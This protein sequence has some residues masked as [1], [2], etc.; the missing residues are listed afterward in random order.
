M[1]S[2][3]R[4]DDPDDETTNSTALATMPDDDGY[5]AAAVE[6]DRHL[7][8]GEIVKFVDGTWSINKV[9]VAKDARFIPIKLAMA[10]VKW[11]NQRPV[12]YVWPKPNGFLPARESLGDTDESKWPAGLD[13][14]PKDP[15]QNTRFIYLTDV[16]TAE[17]HTFTNRTTGIRHCYSALAQAVA[18]MR[19]AHKHALP[20]VVACR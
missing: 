16:K 3:M 12:E 6:A 18:T 9:P 11:E 10:L 17:T 1:E 15:W 5:A 2:I 19:R 7:I 13:G 20:M 8:K 14:R 4:Y